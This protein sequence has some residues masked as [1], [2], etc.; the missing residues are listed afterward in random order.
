MEAIRKYK[1]LK[2]FFCN[3][4]YTDIKTIEGETSLRTPI[5]MKILVQDQGGGEVQAAGIL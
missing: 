2:S 1:E 5:K 3:V 4:D